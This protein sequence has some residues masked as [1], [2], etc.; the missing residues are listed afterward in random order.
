MMAHTQIAQNIDPDEVLRYFSWT[1]F[2]VIAVVYTAYVF[3]IELAKDGPFIFSRKNQLPWHLV[4][5]WHASF[6][7]ILFCCYRIYT[8]FV[9]HLP[10]WLTNTFRHRNSYMSLADIVGILAAFVLGYFERKWLYR[11]RKDSGEIAEG[12]VE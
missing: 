10:Y 11:E 4:L 6:L 7:L 5:L 12:P 1:V 9:P 3:W 2:A 8:A